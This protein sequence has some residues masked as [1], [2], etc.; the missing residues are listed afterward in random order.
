MKL[1]TILDHIDSGLIAL[2][3][4]QRGYVWNREQVRSLMDSL[5][6]EHPVG[7]LLVWVANVD[8]VSYRGDAELASGFVKLLLD[9][10]QR[11]TSLYG[12]IR[13]KPP[14]FFQGNENAFRAL[15]FNVGNEEFRFYQASRMANDPLWIDVTTLMQKGLDAYFQSLRGQPNYGILMARLNKI[16][17]IQQ[18]EFHIDEVTGPDKTVHVVVDIFNRVNS[19]GTTLS[20]GDLAL[21]KICAS[22]PECRNRMNSLIGHYK[23][24]GY[25]FT[26]NWLLRTVNAIVTGEAGFEHLHNTP[27]ERIKEGLQDSKRYID[28]ALNLISGRLGIDHNRVL[29]GRNALPIV[30][31]YLHKRGGRITDAGERDR[32][33]YWY[34][35]SAMWGR[36]SGATESFLNQ[37]LKALE[38][39]EGSID[40]LIDNLRLW[41]GHL[42]IEPAHFGGWSLGARFYP[43]LYALT[44]THDAKDFGTGLSLNSHLLGRMN[45]LEVH[46]IFPKAV[47]Y[48]HGD[49]GYSRTEVNAVANYCFLTKATNLQIGAAPPIEYFPQVEA[50]HP[51]ALASQWIPLDP[52]LW[53]VENYPRFLEERR[54]LLADAANALLQDLLHEQSSTTGSEKDAAPLL[55]PLVPGLTVSGGIES[56]Q[57]QVALAELNNWVC[58]RQ[59]PPGQLE[60]ELAHP[61]SGDPQVILD[62]AWPNGLQEG[63]SQPVAVL[64]DEQRRTLQ[65]ANDHGFRYFTDIP[66]FQEY[67]KTEI[68]RDRSDDG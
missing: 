2:P 27:S 57:E 7:S 6:Y 16:S 49:H 58:A 35:Q 1:S 25:W 26:R 9:G 42:R 20:T 22:W 62:I 23:N 54:R 34:F 11:I 52:D 40:R 38:D 43:V 15:Y 13:G 30:A 28:E 33:L 63:Y 60:Y 51:G 24:A 68:L 14:T 19:Q 64:L 4:F 59:L 31:R 50:S 17:N 36:F 21:A 29:F 48:N 55:A 67:V 8:G 41:H 65:V 32:V 61:D 66:A 37:D 12:I 5:Y 56:E 53:K 39:V 10:Q 18:R 3:E 45:A 46:H 47:L 44:R